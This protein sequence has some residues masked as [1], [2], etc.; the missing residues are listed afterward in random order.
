MCRDLEN[1]YVGFEA[2]PVATVAE[3]QLKDRGVAYLG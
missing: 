1:S 2:K 3:E